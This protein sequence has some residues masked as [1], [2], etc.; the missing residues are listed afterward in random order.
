MIVVK[1]PIGSYSLTITNPFAACQDGEA[2]QIT[3]YLIAIRRLMLGRY[4]DIL[5][6]YRPESVSNIAL[7]VGGLKDIMLRQVS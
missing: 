2:V 5:Q 1:I 4:V 6:N 7:T 3:N